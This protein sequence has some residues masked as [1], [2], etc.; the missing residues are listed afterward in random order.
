[1]SERGATAWGI[2]ETNKGVVM[3]TFS[4]TTGAEPWLRRT[5][6]CSTTAPD[7]TSPNSKRASVNVVFDRSEFALADAKASLT[8]LESR[9]PGGESTVCEPQETNSG[10]MRRKA[11]LL[12][13]RQITK[14]LRQ[15]SP[16]LSW[17]Q[18]W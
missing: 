10:D 9:A 7:G 6:S 8:V 5:N 17:S 14:A 4:I 3:L 12:V 2:S 11:I 13:P 16:E 15:A 1:P 18:P